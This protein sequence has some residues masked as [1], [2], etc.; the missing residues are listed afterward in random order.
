MYI[1]WASPPA[2]GPHMVTDEVGIPKSR[3]LC[4]GD[5]TRK[6]NNFYEEERANQTVQGRCRAKSATSLRRIYVFLDLM[7][8]GSLADKVFEILGFPRG[9]QSGGQ[10]RLEGAGEA[11]RPPSGPRE[12]ARGAPGTES[13]SVRAPMAALT[14]NLFHSHFS[15][16]VFLE[17][18]SLGAIFSNPAL[19]VQITRHVYIFIHGSFSFI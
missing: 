18:T 2:A 1:L 7:V 14:A 13:R 17:P 8:P 9:P 4:Y 15:M 10:E 5:Y 6:Y 11:V 3:F 19:S 16:F 12:R